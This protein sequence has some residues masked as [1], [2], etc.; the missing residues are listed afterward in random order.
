MAFDA[1]GYFGAPD[2]KSE[3]GVAGETQD[4]HYKTLGAFEIINFEFGAENNINIGSGT[5]GGGAGKATFKEGT[6][7]KKTD[8]ASTEM[9]AKLCDGTHFADMTID[10]RRSGGGGKSGEVFLR[11]SFKLVMIQDISWSGA[12]GDDICEETVIMQYGAMKV[13]YTPQ[14]ADGSL[15]SSNMK[16]AEWSRVL[17]QN[18]FAVA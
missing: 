16:T 8:T 7:T 9:F 15:D 18:N 13:F 1:F 14:K 5:Q 12:D 3:K 11:W 17:N 10:L 6:I 4:K 2:A